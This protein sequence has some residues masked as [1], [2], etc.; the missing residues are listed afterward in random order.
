[1]PNVMGAI[2]DEWSR[3]GAGA[4]FLGQPLT[5]ELTCPDGVGRYNHFQG[6]S[7]YW[8]PNTGAHEVHGSIRDKW[9]LMG[10][11]R[12]FLGYP[13]TDET[14]TPDGVGRYNH[15]QGGSIY[16]TA[17][18]GAHEV[19]GAIRDKWASMGWERGF[20]GYPTSDEMDAPG[21]G[22]ISQFQ[23]GTI[24]WTSA[25]GAVVGALAGTASLDYDFN[26]ITFDNG[27][28]VGGSSHLTIRQNGSYTF[29][30]HFHD[31]GATE[32]NMALAWAVKDQREQVY[33]F[34]HVGHVS[35]TFE[36]GSRDDNWVIDGQNDAIAQNWN[37]LLASSTG[38]AKASA[39]LDIV[40]VTNSLIGTIGTVLGV[41]AIVIA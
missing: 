29:Q 24:H 6:G 32:Y 31:S 33:T 20:L 41:V 17:A 13:L 30:G 38:T 40:N 10:W 36:S 1:M 23:Q 5:D 37:N 35:G 4:S 15:F 16:W 3:L 9:S 39:N 34:Q 14:G 21:G 27:V 19:H 28:P 8:T 18:I 7:I 2:R 25:G 26:P 11:E 12:S 22:R